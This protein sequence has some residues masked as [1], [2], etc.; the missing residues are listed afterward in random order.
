M[1]LGRLRS[2]RCLFLRDIGTFTAEVL[3]L[4]GQLGRALVGHITHLE[5]SP[6]FE[7][8]ASGLETVA[9]YHAQFIR[10]RV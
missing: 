7:V 6:E 2:I 4:R 5:G 8:V 9:A 3:L 10:M 1:E